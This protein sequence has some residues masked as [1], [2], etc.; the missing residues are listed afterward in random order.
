MPVSLVT[1]VAGFLGSHVAEELFRRGHTV[2]GLDDLSGGHT[3]NVLSGVEFLQGDVCD[4][5]L[6]RKLFRRH[7]PHHV[8]HLAAYAA[9]GL[10]PF[11][12]AFNYRTNIVG[13]ANLLSQ[14][15][16]CSVERF[17]F[18]SSI[19]VYGEQEPPFIEQMAKKPA[20]PYGLAKATVED[21]L[22]LAHRQ[23]GLNYT[24]F[25]PHNVYG[26]RQN[27]NDPYRNVVGIFIRQCL[28]GQPMTVFGDGSQVRAFSYVGDVAPLLARCIDIPATTNRV[29]N[30]GGGQAV[31]VNDL[32]RAVAEALD[33]PV[34]IEY[35][36]PRNEVQA[37]YC[38]HDAVQDAFGPQPTTSLQEGLSRMVQWVKQVGIG[39]PTAMPCPLEVERGLPA[40][41]RP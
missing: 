38:R 6:V 40:V 9:E 34:R 24:I 29:F 13:S 19:A 39:Q 23:F 15:I 36:P 14:A 7:H 27:I 10:S 37:A 2:V 3:R 17:V 31:S 33:V 25:R 22:E 41:W 16:S 18:A 21:D 5:D 26:E 35:L 20:D 12:R 30:V 1:G 11:I 4:Q 28:S 32:A 8:F